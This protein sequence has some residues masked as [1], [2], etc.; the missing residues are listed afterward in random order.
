MITRLKLSTIEQGLPKYRSMLAGNDAY[1]PN[2]FESIATVTVGSGGA[3][4][5]TFSSIPSTYAHLQ[6]R[7]TAR[8]SESANDS[9]CYTTF[10]GSTSGTDYY[11]LHYLL[12]NGSSASASA[13][14]N[15]NAVYTGRLAAANSGTSI[16]GVGV[17]D[18]LDYANTNKNK[19]VRVLS[20][21]DRNGAGDV[22]LNSGLYISTTAISSLNIVPGNSAS[23]AQYSQFALYGIKG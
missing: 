16:F 21:C 20:G 22:V 2:S 6:I 10:N 8:S 17:I 1:I 13:A 11:Y 23:F 14:D 19:T 7:Y 5:V 15:I 3:S 12:G 18:I 9:W 4:S